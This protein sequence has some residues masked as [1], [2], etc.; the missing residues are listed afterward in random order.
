MSSKNGIGKKLKNLTSSPKGIAL[1]VSLVVVG[2]LIGVLFFSPGVTINLPGGEGF[3]NAMELENA[4]NA[5]ANGDESAKLSQMKEMNDLG[6][7]GMLLSGL[8]NGNENGNGNSMEGFNGENNLSNSNIDMGN[9]NA[10]MN[11]NSNGNANG[12]GNGNRNANGNGNGVG[13]SHMVQDL[14]VNQG[15]GKN[16]L[17]GVMGDSPA[18]AGANV[19]GAITDNRQFPQ[20]PQDQLNA[21][22]LLPKQ[23]SQM[24]A[25][26]FPAGQGALTDRR[27]FL[28]SGFHIGVNTV[29]QS[30]RNANRQLRSDPPN[31]QRIVSPWMNTTISSDINR[32]HFE[33]GGDC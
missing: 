3:E 12:Y 17:D 31:P 14:G 7:P 13:N 16:R 32:K 6:C 28:T 1:I 23:E 8:G 30:L 2:V 20:F 9:A 26:L 15:D 25:D 22:E 29:G 4:M 5:A 33:I 19:M 11:G 10:S 27:D 18:Q 21:T 24:F